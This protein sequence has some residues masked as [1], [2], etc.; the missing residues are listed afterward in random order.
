MDEYT[1]WQNFVNTG[2]VVD[3]LTYKAIINAKEQPRQAEENYG[4]QHRRSDFNR[5]ECRG[6]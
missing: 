2:S 4:V 1:A 5:T 3:Y 6:K